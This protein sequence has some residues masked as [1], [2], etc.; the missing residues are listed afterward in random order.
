LVIAFAFNN[1]PPFAFFAF[2]LSF[3][4]SAESGTEG[5]EESIIE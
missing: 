5:S 4:F 2:D 1:G 3:L